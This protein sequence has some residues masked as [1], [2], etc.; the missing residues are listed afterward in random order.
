MPQ[1]GQ[2]VLAQSSPRPAQQITP[3]G[4]AERPQWGLGASF[5]RDY[6]RGFGQVASAVRQGS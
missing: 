3:R 2:A 6:R 5:C 1:Q 4:K